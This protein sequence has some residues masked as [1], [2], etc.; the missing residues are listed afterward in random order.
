VLDRARAAGVTRFVV[1]AYDGASWAAVAA[2]A[3]Q[4]DSVIPA[5]GLHPWTAGEFLDLEGLRARLIESR[6]G[7][8]G[9]IGLDYKVPEPGHARQREVL[10]R[11]LQLALEL[12]LP[13]ILHCRGAFDDLLAIIGERSG[14]RGVCHAFS[15]GP[16][17]AERC[18]AAG[19]HLGF[20]G[21]VTRLRAKRPRRSAQVA[22]A[23][24]I[25]LETDA[26]SIGLEGVHPEETE[27]R[28]V[29]EIAAT[30]AELRA[31][32]AEAVAEETTRNARALFRF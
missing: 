26:P 9:E 17:L 6:A 28:H 18:L 32:S 25:L 4:F 29:R 15:R 24:R 31:T 5:F 12:D 7:A 27:P 13:V 23:D 8:L 10:V 16:Q 11:Q 20:G 19:L 3:T 1:P 21:T 14:L 2:L 22:P 30:L